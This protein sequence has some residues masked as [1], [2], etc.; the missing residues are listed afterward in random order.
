MYIYIYI[1]IYHY[2]MY[3]III[4]NIHNTYIYICNMYMYIYIYIYIYT[5]MRVCVYI[6]IYIYNYLFRPPRGWRSLESLAV[7]KNGVSTNESG[8]CKS[9]VFWQIGEKGTPWHF[10]EDESRLTGV[11]NKSLSKNRKFAVTPLVLTP[12]VPLRWSS[13]GWPH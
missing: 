12:L 6:Y 10:W 8:R 4:T 1:Y 9:N 11:P 2:N 7:D 5:G 13:T 3:T